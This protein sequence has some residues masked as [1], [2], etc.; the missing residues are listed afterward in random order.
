MKKDAADKFQNELIAS[1]ITAQQNYGCRITRM[2]NQIEQYGAVRTAHNLFGKGTLSDT[3]EEL[4]RQNRLDLTLEAIATKAEYADLFTD[5]EVNYC[6]SL[7][8]DYG[9]YKL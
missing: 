4:A 2:V 6:F 1:C 5:D 7:L 9:Y 8:C 3:F